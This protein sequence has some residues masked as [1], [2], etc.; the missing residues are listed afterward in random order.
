MTTA[1][2]PVVAS[3]LLECFC[4]DP[5]LSGD[6]IEEYA[7]RQS[8][9]WYWKQAIVAATVYPFSQ[10]LEHKWLAIRAI[11]IGYA[12]WYVLNVT[13]LSGVVRPMLDTDDT[14]ILAAYKLMGY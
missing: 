2:P 1:E 11:A 14:M 13:L 4:P 9:L 10:I 12:I 5:G 3:W 6:L 7:R 8:P